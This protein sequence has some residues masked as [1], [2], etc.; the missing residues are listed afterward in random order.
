MRIVHFLALILFIEVFFGTVV[1]GRDD[2]KDILTP[3]ERFWLTQNQSRLVYA[4]ETNYSPFVFIGANGEPTGLA[5]DY[6]LLVASKLG[7]HFKEKRFSSLDDIFSNVRN[8][9]IQI[10]NA[11]TATPKRSEFLSF[12]NFFISVPNVIIVNKNRNG[13]MG[14]KDLTGLR[15]S[16]V[17]S[18]AVTEYLMRKGIVV[19]PNLAANDM[20]ALLDVSFG[21]ADAAVID[22]ATASYLISSNGITNLRVAGETDFNI[23]LAMA[24]SKDEPILRTILQKGIN[25]ITDKEREEIHEHWINT[26]GE[27]IFNDWRFWAVIGGVFVISLVIIIWNRILHNQINL[28]IK[29]EQELQVLNIELR[30]QAN[31]LVSISERLNKAQELAFLGN[32]IW[33]IKSNSLWCSDE[34][35]RI[36][37]LTPQDFKATYE[38]FLERVHPDDR[39][40]V[41]EKVKYTLTY[42]TEYKLTHRII[43][44]DG[45][46]RYVLAVGYVEYEDNKPNK[47]VGMI[48]DITAERVAQ[49]ELEKSEQKYKDLV[50]YAMVGI[51]RSNL[52]GTILYV[53]QTMA[54]MLGYSTPDELIGEK[55][56]LVYKYPEQRGI[57]I[58]KLSQELVVTNYELEL[59]DRYSNT[60]PIM[61]SASLDGEVLSGMIIDMSEIKKS[62]NEINKLSKVIEQIDDTVAITDKQGIITYVNQ[63]FCKH[64]GFTENEVL[65]ESFRILKSD[66]YDNNFYKKLWITISNGDIFRDTV[67]NRKKN[68]DLYYEDKTITPLKDEKDNIIGYV[69]TGKDVTLETLMNQEIQRIATIDQLT[70]IYNRH[71]F[72][73]LF[74]LETERSRRFLQPLSLILIDIDHFKVVNDTY[75]H[76]VGDEVLKTLADV[77]GEN[78]R[79][80]DIFARWGGE[81]FLVLSPNTDLKNVQKLAE[82][83]RSAVENAFFPTVHHVTI[84]LG[85]STFREEDTFTTLFKR[86][87]Q[88]LYYAKEHGRN[89]IGVIN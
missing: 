6:M 85:I 53:N 20:E 22:L 66:R 69:S 73:E 86:I 61:I 57:F 15:V 38:A 76:D 50:E 52:S 79:K 1:Y 78:I 42:K 13:A 81:E 8:H 16:L 29:A 3:Q 36:F 11:V 31:E 67:I 71:K 49:N 55:S 12:T 64:T 21:R 30:R 26:S 58:Q 83:L 70:G 63:A 27:S 47:M 82:K 44:M 77:I 19:T 89:Q 28:R 62:E 51:Y 60:L 2:V 5:Y 33:D 25:A 32:W 37:G 68:G 48:Q 72:E 80:I 43:K 17:K 35:Y 75:G 59:V 45:A 41:E 56:M 24:V 40:I 46:E 87:D 23:Q 18:Y 4:V 39:S 88:G 9:E 10:V 65:G 14:E 54:K 84:S 34:M 74:I 7:V